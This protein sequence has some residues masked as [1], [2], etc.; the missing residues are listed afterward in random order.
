MR[1]QWDKAV[2]D[3]DA[4]VSSP[5]AVSYFTLPK[6]LEMMEQVKA[7]YP[8]PN[9]LPG[10]DFETVPTDP[11]LQWKT[12]EPTIDPVKM[13][14]LRVKQITTGLEM[15]P[16]GVPSTAEKPKEGEQCAMLQ[17]EAQNK[18]L[19]PQALER[20][21]L[22]LSS[23]LVKLPP[24]T[25]VRVSAWVRIPTAIGASADGALFYDTA[26][27]EPLAIRL[28]AATAWKKYT[29]YRKVPASGQIGVT[30]A[31]TGL[32]SVYF[33]DVRIEPLTTTLPPTNPTPGP[34]GPL[35]PVS[36]QQP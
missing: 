11:A 13:T 3:L 22:S 7:L 1:L 33:D 2:K 18:A 28:T 20:S 21:V 9:V 35:T 16:G 12:E 15:K 29:L 25:L 19:P 23:P 17:I 36:G 27:G 34:K 14:P 4:P 31:L 10:G 8:S 30:L 32:G 26:G 24:G 6:H 5:Y